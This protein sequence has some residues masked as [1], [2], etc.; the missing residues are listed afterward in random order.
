VIE[1]RVP[2]GAVRDASDDHRQFEFMIGAAVKATLLDVPRRA[3]DRAR[4]FQEQAD[5]I[6]RAQLMLEECRRH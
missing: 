4:G 6:D 5:L 3:S 2:R 1:R